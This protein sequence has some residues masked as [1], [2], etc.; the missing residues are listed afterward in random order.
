MPTLPTAAPS[1]DTKAPAPVI[2]RTQATWVGDQR[3][4]AGPGTRTHLIDAG[5][6]AGPGP[7]ETLLNALAT[8]SA[9]DVLS[10]LAKRRTPVERLSVHVEGERR[11]TAPRRL[12]R[13]SIEFRIDGAGIEREHAERAIHLS[14]EQYCSVASSLAPDIQSEARL[15]LNGVSHP[16]F[17]LEVAAAP[18]R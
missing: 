8:C 13:V 1:A 6:V 7:I 14:F 3:F 4:E 15:T 5:A 10:I 18:V 17:R 11:P 2:S 12:V 16:P 9:V